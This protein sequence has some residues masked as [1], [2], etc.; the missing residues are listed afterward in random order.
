MGAEVSIPDVTR[1]DWAGSAKVCD[2]VLPATGMRDRGN[3]RAGGPCALVG[4]G[5]AEAVDLGTDGCPE[6]TYRDPVVQCIS[7]FAKEAVLG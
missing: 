4:A 2:D 7:E 3:E 5:T 1:G 6:R